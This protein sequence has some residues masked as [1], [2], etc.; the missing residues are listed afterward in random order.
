M[1]AAGMRD[2]VAGRGGYRTGHGDGKEA[3]MA[4]TSARLACG[5]EK[6][7]F[8]FLFCVSRTMENFEK[9]SRKK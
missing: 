2:A 5:A 4:G 7:L 6:G 9:K 3:I 8:F 1:R